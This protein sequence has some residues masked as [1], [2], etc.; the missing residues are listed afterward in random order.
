MHVQ[1]PVKEVPL[2]VQALSTIGQVA[3]VG[4]IAVT[5]L[6]LIF[7]DIIRKSIFPRLRTADAY[8]LLR[9]ITLC[10]TLVAIGGI[11]AWTLGPH[12]AAA[13]PG[14]VVQKTE[15]P[16]SPAIANTKGNVEVRIE[17]K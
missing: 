3:G 9:L 7:R 13:R 6:L 4:G 5:A 8:R 14:T 2:D 15:G 11:A 12:L 17:Q 16:T 1:C 10:T